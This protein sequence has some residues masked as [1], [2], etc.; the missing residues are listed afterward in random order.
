MGGVPIVSWAA[1]VKINVICLSSLH[2]YLDGSGD[3]DDNSDARHVVTIWG[4]P[5]WADYYGDGANYCQIIMDVATG[6]ITFVYLETES[7][8]LDGIIGLSPGYWPGQLMEW[9]ISQCT[10]SAADL[11]A[12][13]ETAYDVDASSS[14]CGTSIESMCSYGTDDDSVAVAQFPVQNFDDATGAF[15]LQYR[16]LYFTNVD[17]ASWTYELDWITCFADVP[18]A[19]AMTLDLYDDDYVEVDISAHPFT[20]YGVEYDT[21]YVS[22]NGYITF[23]EGA[24]GW[25]SS[26]DGYNRFYSHFALPT[27]A[28]LHDDLDPETYGGIFVEYTDSAWVV[29]Y[30]GICPFYTSDE[31]YAQAKLFTSSGDIQFSYMAVTGSEDALVGLSAGYFPFTDLYTYDLSECASTTYF[32]YSNTVC[33]DVW[34]ASCTGET[35]VAPVQKFEFLYTEVDLAFGYLKFTPSGTSSYDYEFGMAKCLYDMPG[36]DAVDAGIF[37]DDFLKADMGDTFTFYGEDYT[38]VYIGSN[39]FVTFEEGDWDYSD[40]LNDHFAYKRIAVLFDDM[41][42]TED[43]AVFYDTSTSG[44]ISVTWWDVPQFGYYGEDSGNYFQATMFFSTGVI[45]L[46]YMDIQTGDGLVGLSPGY[47]P[48]LNTMTSDLS[49][50]TSQSYYDYTEA[51]CASD[52]NTVTCSAASSVSPVQDLTDSID[53]AGE[54][55]DLENTMLVFTPDGA[56]TG[57]SFTAQPITCLPYIPGSGA[58]DLEM[59]DDDVVDVSAHMAKP[60]PFYSYSYDSM[61]VHTNGFITLG[62]SG[63]Y[64]DGDTDFATDY[65]ESL[66]DHFTTPRISPLFDDL[67]AGDQGGVYVEDVAGTDDDEGRFVA[68]WWE[69][70]HYYDYY[71]ASFFQAGISYNTGEVFI[72]Y[73]ALSYVSGGVIGLSPG[74]MDILDLK[75]ADF[76]ECALTTYYSYANEDG[77]G[78]GG[79]NADDIDD[80]T[81]SCSSA[82]TVAPFEIGT[83]PSSDFAIMYTPN[84]A[85]SKYKVNR[86]SVGGECLPDVPSARAERVYLNDD[87]YAIVDFDYADGFEFYGERY[88][89]CYVGSNGYITFDYGD[90]LYLWTDGPY[91]HFRHKRIAALYADL[92]PGSSY[93]GG[94]AIFKETLDSGEDSERL[95][96]T[97]WEVPEYGYYYYYGEVGNTFQI[98]MYVTTGTITLTYIQA[99]VS[100]ALVGLSPGYFP[101]LELQSVD[102]SNCELDYVYAYTY[103]ECASDDYTSQSVGN[104]YANYTACAANLDPDDTSVSCGNSAVSLAP[105]QLF[106]GDGTTA[107]S[108]STK[109]SNSA[110]TFF[111]DP[112]T[113]GKAGYS[114]IR[115]R[116]MECLIETPT[117]NAVDLQLLMDDYA[118]IDVDGF[119]F[120]GETYERAWV[121]SKAY[122]TFAQGDYTYTE[123]FYVHFN[124]P[125]ISALFDDMDPESYG[126]VFVEEFDAGTEAER[127]AVTWWEVPEYYYT[128]NKA[129]VQ[130]VLYPKTGAITIAFHSVEMEDG[131]VGLSPGY[132]PFLH[133]EEHNFRQCSSE[134]QYSYSYGCEEQTYDEATSCSGAASLAA[135]VAMLT[136][137]KAP[138]VLL[139]R[140]ITFTPDGDDLY[141]FAS[142]QISC[143]PDIPSPDA[144]D[145]Q[146][147]SYYTYQIVEI[148]DGF[149]FYG[150]TCVPG[151]APRAALRGVSSRFLL[152][153]LLLLLLTLSR[154]SVR[155]WKRTGLR[156]IYTGHPSRRP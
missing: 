130:I 43:G 141:S 95:V 55:F 45:Y 115:D 64:L 10:S 114:Y 123:N 87:D 23:S 102:M 9:D 52:D 145:L 27:I 14:S 75:L 110:I 34:T 147:S 97:F 137:G 138:S 146:I 63:Y 155:P 82:N 136:Y 15:D 5:E 32:D 99:T 124:Q 129:T 107:E 142:E 131:L 125:R 88:Q 47:F 127:F 18:S 106:T 132:Y 68:T 1:G 33:D 98:A 8:G 84:S 67:W 46:T 51:S 19:A 81:S 113:N 20:Y 25:I 135:P 122:I 153:L 144:V 12:L 49:A 62:E 2:Q 121:S 42:P 56:G 143:L 117:S 154:P 112:A 61:F 31:A 116:Q 148:E 90:W 78:H 36:S 89:D 104:C 80:W 29:T 74:Y 86:F 26:W 93:I 73:G 79:Q 21:M 94:G 118:L 156:H 11:A 96:V 37:D 35:Q 48:F 6:D 128:E 134:R 4:V 40:N 50:C 152:L 28:V 100:T 83:V 71:G 77:C 111:P 65:T 66:W 72:A 139:K 16:Q 105:V 38:D 22:S 53:Q 108:L 140:A 57:F 59:W 60:V 58:I 30:W 24:S 150:V 85:G 7:F 109:L 101:F 103:D 3:D 151:F 91:D 149:T 120:Y 39:G 126:G 133:L 17:D 41:D 70:Q 44:Q 92:D 69:V 13:Y 76:S 119:T 54:V